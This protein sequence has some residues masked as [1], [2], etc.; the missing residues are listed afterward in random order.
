MKIHTD[1]FQLLK[2]I[3]KQSFVLQ[4]ALLLKGIHMVNIFMIRSCNNFDFKT[5]LIL[6]YVLP[7]S[8][9][10]WYLFRDN[11]F[12]TIKLPKLKLSHSTKFYF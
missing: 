9:A 6:I 3:F 8:C 2:Y 4:L 7:A 5:K 12:L 11:Y 10:W 1:H